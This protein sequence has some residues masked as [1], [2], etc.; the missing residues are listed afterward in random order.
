ML[1]TEYLKKK[2][3]AAGIRAPLWT[4][5]AVQVGQYKWLTWISLSQA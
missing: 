2:K 1:Y 4:L 3:K 5:W